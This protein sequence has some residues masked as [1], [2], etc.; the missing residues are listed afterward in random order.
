[1]TCPDFT[2][3]V[4]VLCLV[5]YL[6]VANGPGA[7][8]PTAT[9]ED[10]L[11]VAEQQFEQGKV[12]DAALAF[13]ALADTY[14][15]EPQPRW[16]LGLIAYQ[17]ARH[18]EARDHFRALV[19]RQEE[20][21]AGWVMLG[22]AEFRL[23]EFDEALPHLELG[24]FLGIASND[25][26]AQTAALHQAFLCNRIGRFDVALGVL[27]ELAVQGKK[28]A[29]IVAAFGIAALNKPWLL[30][31][32]PREQQP[33]IMEAGEAA[34]LLGARRQQEAADLA[35]AL[36]R[37]HPSQPGLHYILGT[38]LVRANW[39]RAEAA[40]RAEVAANPT[41]YFAHVTLASELTDRGR[42]ADAV[43][44]ATEA[45]TLRPDS[46]IARGLLGKALLGAQRADEAIP[47][48]EEAV[49]L[50]PQNA[51]V[52]YS[53]ALAYARVGRKEDAA[54]QREVFAELQQA[55][56]AQAPRVKQ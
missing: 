51:N 41:H 44:F 40:L 26:L 47:Q 24:R 16:Y 38:T 13:R 37:K 56:S 43:P 5:A 46:Y 1:M 50:A 29:G 19:E 7:A 11:R 2:R 54:R 31:D 10:K 45:V 6:L 36:L 30:E 49:K 53:L 42:P 21:G 23:K 9:F 22:L 32:V 35:E 8:Q 25:S 39:E 33:L 12:E 14:P 4:R 20:V 15:T 27:S 3:C 28:S 34:W 52:R 48:L 17:Q 18:L 55:Q